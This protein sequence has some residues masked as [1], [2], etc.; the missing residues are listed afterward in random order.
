MTVAA[1][2]FL[3]LE[4][5]YAKALLRDSARWQSV[6]GA[7][8][9]ESKILEG[10]ARDD[11]PAQSKPRAILRFLDEDDV[12]KTSTTGWQTSGR[13]YLCFEFPTEERDFEGTFQDR[14][15]RFTNHVGVILEEMM[16]RVGQA[17]YLIVHKFTKGP[18]GQALPQDENGEEFFVSHWVLEYGGSP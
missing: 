18:H 1:E 9:A 15:R 12:A 4:L 6:V 10:E 5:D 11:D 8:Q 3:T 16:A 13:I 2:G 17:G 7:A 14:Y